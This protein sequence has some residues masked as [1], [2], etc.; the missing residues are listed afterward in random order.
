[1]ENLRFLRTGYGYTIY[2]IKFIKLPKLPSLK[3]NEKITDIFVSEVDR[4][5]AGWRPYHYCVT[6]T[7][8]VFKFD[9]LGIN[10]TCSLNSLDPI[11]T[12]KI[13]QIGCLL[14]TTTGELFFKQEDTGFFLIEDL[15]DESV[16]QSSELF[17]EITPFSEKVT[18]FF[19]EDEDNT[20]IFILTEAGKVFYCGYNRKF[21]MNYGDKAKIMDLTPEGVKVNFLKRDLDRIYLIT[22][23]NEL[24]VCVNNIDSD[25]GIEK[26]GKHGFFNKT[27][28]PSAIV[29]N[30]R[31][32]F[33]TISKHNDSYT[34]YVLT[35]D[36][37]LFAC[38]NSHCV[39]PGIG[40]KDGR[41]LLFENITPSGEI[42][43]E[44]FSSEI[45]DDYYLFVL[46]AS[47]KLYLAGID[48][49]G[50]CGKSRMEY[51]SLQEVP[52]P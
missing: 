38:S 18:E 28:L 23:N 44:I 3:E 8:K 15:I 2:P 47:G 40:R 42:V 22:D 19:A 34:T 29:K 35:C 24:Y 21:G 5:Y 17:W 4:D 37:Q 13:I 31:S 41:C 49:F 12:I 52:I 32:I 50:L 39:S 6:N 10:D 27:T 11:K 26:K 1:M 43:K 25:L 9:F 14:L 48:R 36:G 46:T 45:D 16:G 7:N 20:D 30:I 33:V 51:F